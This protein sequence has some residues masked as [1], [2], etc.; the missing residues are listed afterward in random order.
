MPAAAGPGAGGWAAPAVVGA[1]ALGGAAGLALGWRLC[2]AAGGGGGPSRRVLVAVS[3]TLQEGFELRKNLDGQRAKAV[4]CGWAAFWNS[5]K[6][7]Y[8]LGEEPY[9]NV[10]WNATVCDVAEPP[11]YVGL[12]ASYGVSGPYRASPCHGQ[13]IS[14]N[15]AWW[16]GYR[17]P[18]IIS[19]PKNFVSPHIAMAVGLELILVS[20]LVQG[21]ATMVR[22]SFAF[23]PLTVAFVLHILRAQ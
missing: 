4:F 6:L 16:N 1:L 7:P 14:V 3:G 18:K 2:R 20:V 17:S 10:T 12:E 22:R 5:T 9:T 13:E 8:T 19:S 15:M 21:K 23:V 11:M